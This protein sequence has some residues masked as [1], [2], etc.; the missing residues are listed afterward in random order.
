MENNFAEE[1]SKVLFRSTV[2]QDAALMKA[3]EEHTRN[4]G[5]LLPTLHEAQLIFGYLPIEVQQRIADGF[6]LPLAKVT[7]VVS[8]YEFFNSER[9]VKYSIRM[10]RNAP[11]HVQGA[12][13]TLKAFENVLGIRVGE[14]TKD[15]KF[16]LLAC[17][18]LGL[19][20]RSPAIMVN[21]QVYG[22]IFYDDV[23]ALVAQFV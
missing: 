11:C 10:C 8:F 1:Q 16:A 22:P 6:K 19:C 14:V 17:D 5:G 21:D 18:C 7:G 4:E 13:E 20:D 3:I 9:P 2:E 15:G 23:A 12:A